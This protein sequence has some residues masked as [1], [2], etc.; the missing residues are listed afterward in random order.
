MFSTK[1]HIAIGTNNVLI[2]L[3]NIEIEGV[4]GVCVAYSSYQENNLIHYWTAT[5]YLGSVAETYVILISLHLS[6]LH[7]RYD[8]QC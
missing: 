3:N 5:N 6:R 7:L 4:F 2:Q 8:D 1:I